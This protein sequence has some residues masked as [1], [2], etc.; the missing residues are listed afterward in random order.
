[1][2]GSTLGH[3]E[4]VDEVGRGGM[5]HVY[6][7]LHPAL[8]RTVA[9]KTLLPHLAADPESV[10]RFLR[11]ARATAK[12]DHPGI[13][14]IYDVGE[15][16]GTYY[17]AMEFLEGRAL[18]EILRDQGPLDV[19]SA[20]SLVRQVADALAHAHAKG[21]LHRDVKPSNI[22]V[23]SN[24]RAVLTDFG[25]ALAASDTRM[26]RAGSSVGSPEYM[27][28][29]QVRGGELDQRADLYS[30]GVLFY[31]LLV[32]EA[33]YT[34]DSAVTVAYKHVNAP[35]QS[36]R[37]RG[38]VVSEHI[39]SVV[40][41]LM[42]KR[43]E[44]RHPSATDLLFDLGGQI[45]HPTPSSEVAYEHRPRRRLV[46]T[47]AAAL[48]L[49]GL[50]LTVGTYSYLSGGAALPPGRGGG[51]PGLSNSGAS[52]SS[53]PEPA[54]MDPASS[55]A[56]GEESGNDPA[57]QEAG[58]D[59]A[60]PTVTETSE[61]SSSEGAESLVVEPATET[62]TITSRPEG[63]EV[64]LDGQLLDQRTPVQVELA[65]ATVYRLSLSL[66][67]HESTGFSGVLEDLSD[68]QRSERSLHFPLSPLVPP[69][70]LTVQT[71]YA[72]QL[73]IAG[74]R[75]DSG[76][77]TEI[78]LPPGVFQVRIRAPDVYLE[79][80]RT[81][82]IES[83]ASATLRL[84]PVASLRVAAT[85][86]N[87]RVKIDNIDIGF[88]PITVQIVVGT[89]DFTF[90]WVTLGKTLNV[91]RQIRLDTGRLFEAAPPQSS[92]PKLE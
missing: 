92:H 52:D 61:E 51:S 80:T 28:P 3:Y 55:D 8:G 21:I 32:G 91:T 2:I 9:I 15:E 88:V 85:P 20:L 38:A 66:E 70:R 71:A 5:G 62:Y 50:V 74:R 19:E 23:D 13:V 57:I 67:G 29:E 49:L 82:T 35:V 54:P 42:S 75:Y 89:H 7:A 58:T 69:G 73:E 22:M 33:P 4:I 14:T 34:G 79:D 40:R 59:P 6:R 30:L 11:E 46:L 26:T 43:P 76:P 78:S 39:D 41:R 86:S 72:V 36:P 68:E 12:L 47:L 53:P 83:D 84:P 31:Q 45:V 10:T 37:Q 65:P 56:S 48:A 18:D 25:I 27:S 90:D 63:A 87:C 44:D 1:M 16:Q 81:V 60:S 24:G 17:F 77:G 64:V